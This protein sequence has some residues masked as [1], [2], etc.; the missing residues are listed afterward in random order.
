MRFILL[1]MLFIS[2]L[3][4]AVERPPTLNWVKWN[5]PP[6]FIFDGPYRNVGLLDLIQ[7]D[8]EVSLPQYTHMTTHANVLR[9]IELAKEGK[10]YC[11]AGW[12]D[13]PQ[14]R[15]LFY[16]SRPHVVIPSNGIIIKEEL[17]KRLLPELKKFKGKPPLSFFFENEKLKSALG[18][19]YGEGIDDYLDKI[20]YLEKEQIIKSNSSLLAFK[21]LFR[22]RV[23]FT[24]GYPFEIKFYELGIA[25]PV[26]LVHIPVS[27]NHPTVPIVF[28]C[29]KT[30][31]GLKIIQLIDNTL[32]RHHIQL[33]ESY[34]DR[35]LSPDD[36][37]KLYKP[38]IVLLENLP[39]EPETLPFIEDENGEATLKRD[40]F[41]ITD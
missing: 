33:F 12:L 35:W 19:R 13:T 18:R 28:A 15:E 30:M 41:N 17:Y 40:P 31:D 25:N 2:T 14:W 10:T 4:H 1:F 37:L 20:N 6:I 26:K 38:R 27:D 9:V 8:M 3:N 29:S 36:I 5:D 21:M 11:N 34:L 23:D 7:Q 24:I 39:Q 32:T 22:D 16:F